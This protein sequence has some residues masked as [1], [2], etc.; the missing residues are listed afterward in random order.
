MSRGGPSSDVCENRDA[1]N[2]RPASAFGWP[3]ASEPQM[4]R[5]RLL[6]SRVSLSTRMSEPTSAEANDQAARPPTLPQ[7]RTATVAPARETPT[8]V[9]FLGADAVVQELRLGPKSVR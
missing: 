9:R 6:G 3:R 8:H 2:A 4:C 1:M 7:P 5:R